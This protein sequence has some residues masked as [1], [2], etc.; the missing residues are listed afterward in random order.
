MAKEL[1]KTPGDVFLY[2]LPVYSR[3]TVAWTGGAAKTGTPVKKSGEAFAPAG[4][5]DAADAAGLLFADVKDGAREAVIVARHAV[6][7]SGGIS[8]PD[9]ATGNQKAAF[10]AAL[11]ALGIA[12][13]K[14]V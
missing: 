12:I 14:T 7:K 13:R 11:E 9:G 1:P 3:E 8:W 2:D 10:H 4:A 6:V 5:N